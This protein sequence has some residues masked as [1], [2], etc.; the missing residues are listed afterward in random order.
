MTKKSLLL[1]LAVAGLATGLSACDSSSSTS[2]STEAGAVTEAAF[3]ESCTTQGGMLES[4]ATCQGTNSCAGESW[5]NGEVKTHDCSG[6]SEC[7]GFNCL[8]PADA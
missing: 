7:N 5:H 2:A 8:I 3:K 4:L 6:M 1:S